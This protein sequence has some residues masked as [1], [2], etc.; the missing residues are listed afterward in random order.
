MHLSWLNF[1]IGVWIIEYTFYAPSHIGEDRLFTS[2][3]SVRMSAGMTA[4]PTGRFFMRFYIGEIYE[5][6]SR[7]FRFGWFLT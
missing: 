2:P 5:N 6:M 4:D 3:M 7:K 1:I